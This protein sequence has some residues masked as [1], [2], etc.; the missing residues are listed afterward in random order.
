MGFQIHQSVPFSKLYDET[1]T[2][3]FFECSITQ[4]LCKQLSSNLEENLIL[5]Q[6]LLQTAFVE[7]LSLNS[8]LGL[9]QNHIFLIFKTRKFARVT[10]NGLIKNIANVITIER[11]IANNDTKKIEIHNSEWE[12]VANKFKVYNHFVIQE[13]FS[14]GC[15]I[16]A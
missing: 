8:I 16:Q 10:L 4:K 5:L 15:N 7:F 11:N 3:I 1:V 14:I 9:I 12:K 13:Q 2:H 6:L